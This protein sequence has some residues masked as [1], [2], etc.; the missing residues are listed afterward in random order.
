M[1]EA[2]LKGGGIRVHTAVKDR[3]DLAFSRLV[4]RRANRAPLRYV[5]H[6]RWCRIPRGVRHVSQPKTTEKCFAEREKRYIR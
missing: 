2:L 1:G 3:P 5:S 4:Y 6:G